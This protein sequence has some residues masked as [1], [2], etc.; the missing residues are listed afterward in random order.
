MQ[1]E[2]LEG[3]LNRDKREKWRER[4]R[5]LVCL[6]VCFGPPASSGQHKKR[7]RWSRSCRVVFRFNRRVS[8]SMPHLQPVNQLILL[9]LH[10]LGAR[11]AWALV[12]LYAADRKCHL[13]EGEQSENTWSS[14]IQRSG[15][16]GNFWGSY[17]LNGSLGWALLFVIYLNVIVRELPILATLPKGVCL[18]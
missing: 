5:P 14:F 18:S 11:G 16:V 3:V 8:K 1:G 17:W 12:Q 10:I 2:I 6:C 15:R 4:T 9:P 13:K 7:Q